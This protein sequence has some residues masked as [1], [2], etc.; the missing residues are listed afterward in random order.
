[1]KEFALTLYFYSPKSYKY[2]RRLNV[3]LP[4]PSTL[5]KWISKFNCSPGFLQEVFL[6]LKN[7]VT[8]KKYLNHVSLTFDAM[9]IRKQ[10]IF[11]YNQGKNVGYVNLGGLK[12]EN[13]E[14][15]ATEALVFQIVSLSVKF[16]CVVGYFFINKISAITLSQLVRMCILKLNEVGV[17]VQNVTFDGASTNVSALVKL[18]CQFSDKPYFKLYGI[19]HG[20]CVMLDP[21]HM[22]KL[23]RNTLADMRVIQSPNGTVDYS[24]MEKLNNLQKEQG[25]KLANK[26]TC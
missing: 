8:D 7:N 1:M 25:L 18:G 20:I 10:V 13:H 15:L 11:Y 22:L 17:N 4:N 16:K 21:P 24:Y 14:E 3:T 12:T 19:D 2:L 5:R 26:L 6:Y 9:S 23:S